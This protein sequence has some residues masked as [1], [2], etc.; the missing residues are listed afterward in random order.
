MHL[1][2]SH[3]YPAAKP[4]GRAPHIARLVIPPADFA[5]QSPFLLM[6]ED[7][8]APPGGF[9]THPHRGM[10][11]VTFVLEGELAHRDHMGS[12]GVLHA[13]DVQFMTAGGGVLHSELPGPQGVH[14][15]QLWLNLPAAKK[16]LGA[17]YAD[18][19][20][21]DAPLYRDG[22]TEIRVY[23]GRVGGVEQTHG[24]AWPLALFDLRLQAGQT[25][26]LPLPAGDRTFLYVLEGAATIGASDALIA[27][28]TV[29]WV[30][31][32]PQALEG[33]DELRV[34]AKS[35]LR[36]LI[37]SSPVIDEPVAARGPFV[38]NTEDELDQAYADYRAGRLT[39]AVR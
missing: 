8:F 33:A 11:T 14:T 10:E 23:A 36:A 18:L 20:L 7:W 37:F 25:F 38:M 22:G 13:G 28:Q 15:L 29:A 19:R 17:R 3:S 6:A 26:D 27:A 1:S 39:Q 31:R 34:S 5:G 21:T 24:S 35:A 30:A 12:H 4:E 16:M 9:P 32:A 2:I